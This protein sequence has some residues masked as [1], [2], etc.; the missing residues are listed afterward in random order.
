MHIKNI[1]VGFIIGIAARVLFIYFF[2]RLQCSKTKSKTTV[3]DNTESDSFEN[4]A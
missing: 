2:E 3:C 4:I 1:I